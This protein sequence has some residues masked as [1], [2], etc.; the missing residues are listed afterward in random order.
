MRSRIHLSA[1][2]LPEQKKALCAHVILS[3]FF[4]SPQNHFRLLLPILCPDGDNCAWISVLRF[5]QICFWVEKAAS[6]CLF[7]TTVLSGS[8]TETIPHFQSLWLCIARLSEP[9]PEDRS[10]RF[11]SHMMTELI[12]S[13][14]FLECRHFGGKCITF[15]WQLK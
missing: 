2:Q 9:K 12:R 3:S 6:F 5:T 1:I 11:P 8:Y 13:I 10:Q 15:Q 14:E 4:T 7:C